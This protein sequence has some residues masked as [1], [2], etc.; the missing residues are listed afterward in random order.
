MYRNEFSI[1]T[2]QRDRWSKIIGNSSKKI[3][4]LHT[5]KKC[6]KHS[7]CNSIKR[8]NFILDIFD[9]WTGKKIVIPEAKTTKSRKNSLRGLPTPPQPNKRYNK[10][11]SN[12]NNNSNIIGKPKLKIAPMITKKPGSVT[13]VSPYNINKKVNKNKQRLT[14]IL[15]SP[16]KS[17]KGG[18]KVVIKKY[19]LGM[20]SSVPIIYNDTESDNDSKKSQN[21]DD[22]AAYDEYLKSVNVIKKILASNFEFNSKN[23]DN[24][25]DTY[26]HLMFKMDYMHM[27]KYH[28]DIEDNFEDFDAYIVTSYQHSTQKRFSINKS[29]TNNTVY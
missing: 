20:S 9:I 26:D 4:C 23:K 8:L 11:K 5:I 19:N 16:N 27:E 15:P 14:S 6:N 17:T 24:I 28:E 21:D 25:P 2:K 7:D 13:L 18:T 3:A 10:T 12:K 22:D 29:T 1:T